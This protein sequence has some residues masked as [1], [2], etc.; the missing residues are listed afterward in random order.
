MRSASEDYESHKMEVCKKQVA[1][2]EHCQRLGDRFAILDACD[3]LEP[4]PPGKSGVEL[5]HAAVSDVKEQKKDLLE[6]KVGETWAA[7]GALIFLGSK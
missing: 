5:I 6:K 1:V 2:L 7:N 3:N 4:D